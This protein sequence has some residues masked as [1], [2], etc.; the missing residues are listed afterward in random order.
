MLSKRSKHSNKKQT[1][2]NIS[3]LTNFYV[4]NYQQPYHTFF[5]SIKPGQTFL[6][7]ELYHILSEEVTLVINILPDWF[8]GSKHLPL[9]KLLGCGILGNTQL[10]IEDL[11]IHLLGLQLGIKIHDHYSLLVSC[12]GHTFHTVLFPVEHSQLIVIEF[13]TAPLYIKVQFPVAIG[14]QFDTLNSV[15]VTA[16]C[17]IRILFSS[18]IHDS[19]CFINVIHYF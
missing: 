18:C 3:Y 10:H 7:S 1:K 8:I 5:V 4:T 6:S 12:I 15:T 19:I 14:R 11:G 17:G 13:L 2:R 9:H 16:L